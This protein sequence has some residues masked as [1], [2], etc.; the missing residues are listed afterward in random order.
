MHN[1]HRNKLKSIMQTV[2]TR[3]G[4]VSTSDLLLSARLAKMNLPEEFLLKPPYCMK[5]ASGTFDSNNA[6]RAV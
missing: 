5:Y 1:S 2:S 3:Q 6:P 4:E